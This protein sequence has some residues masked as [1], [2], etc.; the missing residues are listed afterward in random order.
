M[1]IQ[2]LNDNILLKI[3]KKETT[4]MGFHIPEEERQAEEGEVVDPGTSDMKKG[5]KVYFKDYSVDY[6]M[7]GTEKHAFIK[8]ENLLGIK[9]KK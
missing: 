8:Y 6:V 2:P 7:I 9:K 5:D 3:E 4:A 1:K